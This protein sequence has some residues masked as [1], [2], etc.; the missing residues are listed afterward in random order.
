MADRF[1]DEGGF[2]DALVDAAGVL[3]EFVT[4]LAEAADEIARGPARQFADGGHAHG[5]Q[6]LRGLRPQPHRSSTAS[7]A[8]KSASAP[9]AMTLMARGGTSPLPL[10]L[11]ALVAILAI[12]LLVPAPME[13]GSCS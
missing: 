9:G 6:A 12:S 3:A 1:G 10:R 8:R 2:D 4:V 7:G 5:A 11:A 13:Q